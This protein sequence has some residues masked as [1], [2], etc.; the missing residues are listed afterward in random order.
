VFFDLTEEFISLLFSIFS[1]Y[2]CL[3][4]LPFLVSSLL[5]IDLLFESLQFSLSLI[6]W[7]VGF[8]K[9][10]DRNFSILIL[11][12]SNCGAWLECSLS[13]NFSIVL[14]QL[15]AQILSF[16]LDFI[17]LSDSVD[18]LLW[19]LFSFKL[20][21]ISD[22]TSF[23]VYFSLCNS[24]LFVILFFFECYKRSIN[25]HHFSVSLSVFSLDFFIMGL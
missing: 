25:C 24:C 22:L 3:I 20:K 11:L 17:T 18:C 21:S 4:I 10:I 19:S 12:R 8:Q 2:C 5:V 16:S 13:T 7:S 9:S 6:D 23:S 15:A 1:N 14:R